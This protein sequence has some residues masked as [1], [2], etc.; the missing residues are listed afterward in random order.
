ME[1]RSSASRTSGSAASMG[2]TSFTAADYKGAHEEPPGHLRAG[3]H[4]LRLWAFERRGSSAEELSRRRRLRCRTPHAETS[5][6]VSGLERMRCA[7]VNGGII[8][9][10][11]GRSARP[12]RGPSWQSGKGT[13]RS[14]AGRSPAYELAEV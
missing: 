14:T 9:R 5:R 6:S 2:R 1:R 7:L 12:A 11:L 3:N 8:W 10:L 13:R 4:L